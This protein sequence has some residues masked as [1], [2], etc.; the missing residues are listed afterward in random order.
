MVEVGSF[1]K[2]GAILNMAPSSITRSID[3]LEKELQ[4]SL[5]SRSTR[6]LILTDKGNEFLQ[7]ATQLIA[8]ANNLFSSM[9]EDELE[10]EGVI[11][12]S[13]FES[14]GRMHVSP[15][16]PG[17]LN[18][19][20]KVKVEIELENR[21]VDLMSENIDLAIRIGEPADS[22]LKSR[23]LLS[24]NNILCASPD[25]LQKNGM[26]KDPLDL[27]NHNCLLLGQNK[28]RVHWYF[29]KG[30]MNKKVHV[31]GNLSSK[32]GSPL[33]ESALNGIGILHLASWMVSEH[34]KDGRLVVC[35][36]DWKSYIDEKT[37][38]EIFIVYKNT[39]YPNP[40]IRIF[41]DYLVQNIHETTFIK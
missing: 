30:R 7:G 40:L 6:Q 21:M 15:L 32:G 28:Q 1:S 35:L 13:V 25:Y 23:N 5:F 29:K 36:Q 34:I 24:N 14:F 27:M 4:V 12:V 33:V 8:D 20:P 10:P 3:S 9:H 16:L 38:S 18:M 39:K 2:A 19:Y 41:I 17:F 26:P 31:Q 22:N 11:R 37:T